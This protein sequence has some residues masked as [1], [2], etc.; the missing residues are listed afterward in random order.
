MS[1]KISVCIPTYN[2]EAFLENCLKSVLSQTFQDIEVVIADDRSKDRTLEIARHFAE[3]DKRIK[4]YRNPVNCGPTN[5]FNWCLYLAQGEWVKFIFQD[6]LM[7]SPDF[8]ERM[9]SQVDDAIGIACCR[10]QY[11][12]DPGVDEGLMRWFK[13]KLKQ[14]DDVYPGQ[15]KISA[16]EVCRAALDVFPMNLFGE[17]S[18]LLLKRDLIREYGMFNTNFIHSTDAELSLRIASNRGLVFISDSPVIIHYHAKSTSSH[19]ATHRRYSRDVLDHLVLLHE[20]NFHPVFDRMREEARNGHPPV[21]LLGKF[22]YEVRMARAKA[23]EDPVCQEQLRKMERLYPAIR[24]CAGR[25]KI[26]STALNKV[27][28]KVG[29]INAKPIRYY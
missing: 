24:L 29:L 16:R 13:E 11:V 9:I 19:N 14:W 3:T 20:I 25:V 15:T 22:S 21:D 1:P 17:P 23:G 7:A 6:D 28:G 27:F 5:N 26:F 12:F 18:A 2:G 8:L 4:V 10:R